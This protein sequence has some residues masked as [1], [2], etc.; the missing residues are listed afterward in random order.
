MQ[1]YLVIILNY[2]FDIRTIGVKALDSV[3]PM[4]MK[5][6]LIIVK[7]TRCGIIF[8]NVHGVCIRIVQ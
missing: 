1:M 5:N 7:V 4:D 8:V 6:V 3:N 2:H